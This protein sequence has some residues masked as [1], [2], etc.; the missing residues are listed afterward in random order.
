M[1]ENLM[2]FPGPYFLLNIL[3]SMYKEQVVG[4][5]DSPAEIKYD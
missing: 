3:F 1:M 5:Y 2:H 4:L